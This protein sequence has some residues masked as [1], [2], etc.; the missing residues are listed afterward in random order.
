M[1]ESSPSTRLLVSPTDSGSRLDSFLA[2]STRLSRRAARRLIGEDAVLLNRSVVRILS[3]TVEMGDLIEV[4]RIPGELGVPP[5]PALPPINILL[6]DGWIC[7]VD[8]PAGLL[9]QPAARRREGELA[10]NELL[11]LHLALRQGERP[12]VRL[13]HRLDRETSGVMLFGRCPDALPELAAAW[14]E[15]RCSR[16]YL[17]IVEGRPRFESKTID[18]PLARDRGHV[19]RFEVAARGRPARTE[20][21]VLGE[22][23]QGTSLVACTLGSGRTHQVRVH[24]AHIGHPIAGDR[25]YGAGRTDAPRALLHAARLVLPHPRSAIPVQVQ[26]PLPPDLAAFLPDEGHTPTAD[27]LRDV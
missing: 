16:T 14:R 6:E 8:K 7:G 27:L 15:E 12:Y 9:S 1:N 18:A 26:A 23:A 11:T 25:L 17:A 3:R 21:H 4:R 2:A 19:W 13:V 22:G 20:V 10:M 24:L 5:A